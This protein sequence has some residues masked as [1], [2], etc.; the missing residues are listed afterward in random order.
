MA[1]KLLA[2]ALIVQRN[3]H[4][5]AGSI[6]AKL[7]AKPLDVQGSCHAM[8]GSILAGFQLRVPS[9]YAVMQLMVPALVPLQDAASAVVHLQ[10]HPQ[11][12]T[13]RAKL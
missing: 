11:T 3:G 6:H 10:G 7:L 13:S 12:A 1:A 4:A 8:T 2:K 9:L 5:M